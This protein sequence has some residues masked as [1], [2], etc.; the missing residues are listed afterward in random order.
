MEELIYNQIISFNNDSIKSH[1]V[2]NSFVE[3]GELILICDLEEIKIKGK[4]VE[5][6]GNK[7]RIRELI[8]MAE[9]RGL[10]VFDMP[11]K[12]YA[13]DDEYEYVLLRW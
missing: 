7:K 10:S 3:N 6:S 12:H 13:K 4:S 2:K 8:S 11:V 9:E 1:T 5:V